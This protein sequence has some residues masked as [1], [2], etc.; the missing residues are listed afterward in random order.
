MLSIILVGLLIF[1]FFM[2][3]KRGFILQLFHLLGFAIAFIVAQKYYD[4]LAPKLALWIPYPDLTGDS[5]WTVFLQ[6]LPLENAFYHAISFVAIFFTTKIILQIVTTMLDFIAAIPMI[7]SV[8][9]ILGAVL[10]F[11]EVYLIA[12]VI[13]FILALTPLERIQTTIGQSKVAVYMI[14]QTPYLSEKLHTLWF[15][16]VNLLI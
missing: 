13:L 7:R 5:G 1:G 3:L 12:F 16:T 10:G 11:A 2:G 6:T 9:K 15:S 4:Q 14:E 8:N